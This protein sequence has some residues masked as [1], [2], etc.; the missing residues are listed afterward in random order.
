[1]G[2][3]R[4]NFTSRSKPLNPR[5]FA[6]YELILFCV[7]SQDTV[8]AAKQLIGCIAEGGAVLDAAKRGRERGAAV[9]GISAR[10]GDGRQR[11]RRRRNRRAWE[12]SNGR[13][14]CRN[15]RA[16]RPQERAPSASRRA[17]AAPAC[18]AS[19]RRSVTIRW[20]KLMGNNGTNTV[21]TL[22]RCSVGA[23][24]A[25][26][27]GVKLVRE[28]FVETVGVGKAEAPSSPRS[29]PIGKSRR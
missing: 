16:R 10:A 9:R 20:H 24:L 25:D 2:R 15:R 12:A 14:K 19:D 6:P 7:K 26:P 28:L 11:A 23:A 8:S 17:F 18:W 21:C 13:R 5:E 27:E 1:M 4:A 22:G 29:R 3:H